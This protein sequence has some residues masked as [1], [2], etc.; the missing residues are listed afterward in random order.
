MSTNQKTD[1]HYA[2]NYGWALLNTLYRKYDDNFKR[3]RIIMTLVAVGTIFLYMSLPNIFHL[4]HLHFPLIHS[5]KLY[6]ALTSITW[7]TAEVECMGKMKMCIS[8]VESYMDAHDTDVEP[9]L[10]EIW[11][12]VFKDLYSINIMRPYIIIFTSALILNM[13]GY[14]LSWIWLFAYV[15]LAIL[16]YIGILNEYLLP[17]KVDL[18]KD[19]IY[20]ALSDTKGNYDKIAD[21]NIIVAKNLKGYIGKDGKLMYKLPLDLK[22]FKQKTIGKIVIMGRKTF[23]SIGSKPLPDR[24]NIIITSSKEKLPYID[25]NKAFQVSDP[26]E[27]VALAYA[28]TL[29]DGLTATD[30]IWIIGG[31]SIYESLMK[32]VDKIYVTIVSDAKV[33]DRKIYVSKDEFYLYKET[34]RLADN[35]YMTQR[36]IF[37]R[38]E[39]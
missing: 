39:E 33:G 12:K 5:I 32:F 10:G 16:L 18:L 6:C 24:Q 27:A 23:E 15:V 17:N 37:K 14:Q 1:I 7:V 31:A 2:N 34:A 36:K 4:C 26:I 28:L 11:R 19:A 38:K 35:G 22:Y 30:R 21:C 3:K 25:N 20:E 13:L 29:K 9:S 8:E